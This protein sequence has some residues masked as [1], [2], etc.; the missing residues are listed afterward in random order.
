[1]IGGKNVHHG[2]KFIFYVQQSKHSQTPNAREVIVGRYPNIKERSKSAFLWLNDDGWK[3][4]TEEEL[5]KLRSTKKKKEE[6][7][8]EEKQNDN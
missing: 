5:T 7:E 2:F 1:F 6:E 3:D 4:I 8:T